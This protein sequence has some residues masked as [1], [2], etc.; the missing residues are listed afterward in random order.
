MDVHEIC[1]EILARMSM[2]Q[3]RARSSGSAAVHS[4]LLNEIILQDSRGSHSSII[5]NLV[6]A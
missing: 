3:Q 6:H 5:I 1:P 4:G 2:D